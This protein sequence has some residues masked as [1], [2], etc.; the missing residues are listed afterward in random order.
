MSEPTPEPQ[1]DGADFDFM[2][3]EYSLADLGTVVSGKVLVIGCGGGCDI[4]FVTALAQHLR[5]NSTGSVYFTA[6]T[7]G[8][9]PS[10]VDALT[11]V[12]GAA[13]ILRLPSAVVPVNPD[14]PTYGST[15]VEQSMPRFEDG[16]PYIFC[17]PSK[18]KDVD[19]CTTENQ[20]TMIPQIQAQG[21]DAIIG[22]DAGGDGLTGGVDFEGDVAL[23]RDVQMIGVLKACGL[24]FVH[25]VF[26]P[27]CDGESQEA[28][29]R[30][31]LHREKLAGS[32]CGVF[33]LRPLSWRENCVGLGA[34]RTPMVCLAA[35]DSDDPADDQSSY[36]V[37]QRNIKPRIPTRWLTH[38]VVL[39][40]NLPTTTST[41]THPD[42]TTL[43]TASQGT[44]TTTTV[45]HPDG[46]VVAVETV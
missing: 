9:F 30:A 10:D 36:T 15:A 20:S 28:Q 5:D 42:G 1:L 17:L 39:V 32:F 21:F 40:F 33:S 37:I 43:V 29:M 3:D 27:G 22:V 2:A 45:T 14:V 8:G 44:R 26:G 4:V 19:E 34:T 12:N 35:C 25:V 7:K 23:G 41:I 24:P 16:S 18:S 13:N 11:A 38:A 46:T 6:N 31:A